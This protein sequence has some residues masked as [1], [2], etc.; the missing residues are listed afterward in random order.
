MYTLAQLCYCVAPYP[1]KSIHG[2]KISN[3]GNIYI[4]I[5]ISIYIYIYIY[6]IPMYTL[7]RIPVYSLGSDPPRPTEA[8]IDL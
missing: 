7:H 3:Q 4:Y 1:K 8:L 6:R 5:Y 2:G